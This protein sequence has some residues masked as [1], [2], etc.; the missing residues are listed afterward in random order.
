MQLSE[1]GCK[2]SS[3]LKAAATDWIKHACAHHT[4]LWPSHYPIDSAGATCLQLFT[5]KY[6]QRCNIPLFYASYSLNNG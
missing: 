5:I 3:A 2:A 1:T 4:N 6:T